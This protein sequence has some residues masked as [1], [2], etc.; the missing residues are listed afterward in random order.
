MIARH[1]ILEVSMLLVRSVAVAAA[2]LMALFALK[3]LFAELK[4]APIQ[5][6]TGQRPTVKLRQDPR[7]GIYHPEP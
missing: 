7:T 2:A 6:Q 3:R 5:P 1:L 4:P